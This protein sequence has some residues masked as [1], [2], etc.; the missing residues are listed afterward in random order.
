M[1]NLKDSI[2]QGLTLNATSSTVRYVLEAKNFQSVLNNLVYTIKAVRANIRN[3]RMLNINGDFYKPTDYS[4]FGNISAVVNS[5][6]V[7]TTASNEEYVDPYYQAEYP[8]DTDCKLMTPSQVRAFINNYNS[9]QSDDKLVSEPV[10]DDVVSILSFKG[11]AAHTAGHMVMNEEGIGR[12]DEKV[13]VVNGI[14]TPFCNP[15]TVVELQVCSSEVMS[16]WLVW[17]R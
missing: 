17:N 8:S 3:N 12:I 5:G 9:R 14:K 13:A 16:E 15:A 4:F 2:E 7:W 1:I 11:W 6:V 10:K